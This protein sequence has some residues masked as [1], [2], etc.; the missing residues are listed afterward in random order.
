MFASF[1][2]LEVEELVDEA[3]EA[4]GV[5]GCDCDILVFRLVIR[6]FFKRVENKGER[7][8]KLVGYILE[9]GCFLLVEFFKSC[10]LCFSLTVKELC[11]III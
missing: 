2:L 5:F 8:A 9:E 4:A 7:C 6:F 11:W 3:E 10:R 1:E